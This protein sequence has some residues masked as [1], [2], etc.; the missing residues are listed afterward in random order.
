MK[1]GIIADIH[2]NASAL[3]AVL[4]EF[5][6]SR[7]IDHIFCLG[8]MVAIGPDTNEVLEI[9]FSRNDVSIITGN[10][11]EA[12]LALLKGEEHPLSHFYV[13]EHHQWV[14]DNMDKSFIPKLEQLPRKINTKIDGLSILFIHY[15]I[16]HNK[17]KKHISKDPFSKIVKPSLDNLNV[18]FKDCKEDLIC[19]GHHHPVHY[20]KSNKTIYLNPSS[21]GC[22]IKPTAPYSIVK[23]EKEIEI[24]LNEV[25][26]DN[27]N[28]LAS[29]QRLQIPDRDFIMKVFH[30][31]QLKQSIK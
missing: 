22:N 29:Y 19:F 26:Y 31:N 30:G 20:F 15:H 23:I 21:L 10:H 4:K 27:T 9:L 6:R 13:K 17:L 8:D 14:A 11:D 18:L 25:A 2:G 7:K 5:D 12:V 28:F 3:K 1:I 24:S 16:E